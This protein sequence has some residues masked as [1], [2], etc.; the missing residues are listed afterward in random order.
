MAVGTHPV[1]AQA[2]AAL[3]HEQALRALKALRY[4]CS[5]NSAVAAVPAFRQVMVALPCR[6]FSAQSSAAS[7]R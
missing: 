5:G 6:V 4:K 7:M 3:L 2:A 1:A